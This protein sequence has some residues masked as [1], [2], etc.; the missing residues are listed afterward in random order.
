MAGK[1]IAIDVGD[2]HLKMVVAPE[3][4]PYFLK[5]AELLNEILS[6]YMA[7]HKVHDFNVLIPSAAVSLLAEKYFEEQQ[8]T[9]ITKDLNH[10]IEALNNLLLSVV[11]E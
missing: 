9:S 4:E 10:Q 1:P 7:K 11:P 5:A 6:G 3:Q 8:N 2:K